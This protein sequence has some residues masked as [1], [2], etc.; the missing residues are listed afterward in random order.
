MSFFSKNDKVVEELSA[1]LK[2][3]EMR[4]VEVDLEPVPRKDNNPKAIQETT[5]DELNKIDSE[6]K[7]TTKDI[8]ISEQ[9]IKRL[10]KQLQQINQ[11]LTKLKQP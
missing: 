2:K 10:E 9:E 1:E 4:Q 6:I 11:S 8:S 7:K 5:E 3:K